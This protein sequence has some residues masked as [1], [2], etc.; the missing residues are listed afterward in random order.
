MNRKKDKAKKPL[1]SRP[2][3]TRVLMAAAMTAIILIVLPFSDRQSF[4]YELNQPWRYALLTADFDMPIM[5]D[6]ASIRTL[7][8][9]VDAR[10]IPFVVHDKTIGVNNVERFSTSLR[11]LGLP[12]SECAELTGMLTAAYEDGIVSSALYD[13]LRTRKITKVRLFAGTDDANSVKE[14]DATSLLSPI[15]AFEHIDSLY[16]ARSKGQHRLSPQA[17]DVITRALVPNVII[18]SAFDAKYRKQEYLNVSAAIG[19]IK[20]GQRIV[21]RGEIITPQIFTNLN[22]YQQMLDENHGENREHTYFLVGNGL[23]IVICITILYLYLAL[24]RPA[25]W[26]D[27]KKMLFLM[28]F[29]T[30]F[31]VF[32]IEM[33]RL[34]PRG[35]T[36]VPFAAVPIIIMVFADSRTAIFSLLITVLVTSLV[37]TFPFSF[38][39]SELAV[40]LLATFSL[41]QLSKRSQL[42]RTALITFLAYVVCYVALTLLSEGTL[43][44]FSWR[45]VM[46]YG[47]NSII[48]SFAYV[49]I[50]L[51][52]KAFGFTSTVTLV[53]LSDINNPLLRRLAEEAPGTF[54]HSMQVSTL[55]SEAARAIG[56]NTQLTRTG[57]LYHDIGK[58]ESPVF[59]TENQHGVNP[60]AGL[61]PE[62]S[63]QKIIS[64]VTGGLEMAS[65][66]KLPSVIK[67]FI[68]QH[69]GRGLTKY[70]YNTAVN[71]RGAE[72]TDPE[73]FRY[74]GPNPQ[75]KETAIMMMAD[76]VEAASRSLR[77]YSQESI[78]RLV[79]NIVDSQIKDGLFNE[80]PISFQDIQKIKKTFKRRLATI[81]HT[82][83]AYP[84]LKAEAD[85]KN[86]N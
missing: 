64:H 83:I 55:A 10:F 1:L 81:Y 58:M 17:A 70:F 7:K 52:E 35:L 30:L 15:K 62:T 48:L 39:F 45:T 36:Y 65:K 9:S 79:D 21:D 26:E 12:L 69:H 85:T 40:G 22:T 49:L 61:D 47:I 19:V 27:R 5:R 18:D 71:E 8:D 44:T 28:S 76:A 38:I 54:Q 13:D 50:W 82:R 53:E 20:K 42:L 75:S 11:G 72:N 46:N 73:K 32:G 41:K 29:I 60:H 84:K 51:I 14:I 16:A 2:G 86:Q 3:W 4:T 31:I 57:A 80:S 68:S 67:D 77:D 63:A 25:I 43:S 59:F 23:F 33:F 66:E 24:Y 56:A 34:F 6:S 74:P 78:D 37:A